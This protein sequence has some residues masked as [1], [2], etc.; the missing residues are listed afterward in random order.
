VAKIEREQHVVSHKQAMALHQAGRI[1]EAADMYMALLAVR[2][3]DA[4]TLGLFGMAQFQLGKDEEAIAAW[5]KSLLAEAP[6]QVR[7]R[8]IA[9]ILTVTRK[10]STPQKAF[11]TALFRTLRATRTSSRPPWPS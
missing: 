11:S 9:N 2:P 4:E 10:R 1:A 5:R 3:H 6:A 8:I 7:L